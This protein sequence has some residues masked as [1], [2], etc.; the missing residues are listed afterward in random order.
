M[1]KKNENDIV[2]LCKQLLASFKKSSK[3]IENNVADIKKSVD[4]KKTVFC[5]TPN[6]EAKISDIIKNSNVPESNALASEIRPSDI[7]E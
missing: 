7:R 5:P 3:S 6:T 4:Q 1:A 2:L